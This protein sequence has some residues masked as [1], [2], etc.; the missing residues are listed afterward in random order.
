[1]QM[2]FNI[3]AALGVAV[4]TSIVG[5]LS[6]LEIEKQF[7]GQSYIDQATQ[8]AQ[9]MQN[10][11]ANAAA[12]ILKGLPTDTAS[13][14]ESAVEAAQASSIAVSMV[15]LGVIALAGAI[16]ALFVIGKRREPEH[17]SVK[18]PSVA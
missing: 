17:L 14:I 7:E 5:T 4:V 15:V 11:D 18:E 16:F 3:P 6:L 12:D 10:G 9:A 1:M 2:T 13:S 8:Y